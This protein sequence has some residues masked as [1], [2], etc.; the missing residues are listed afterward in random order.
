[1]LWVTLGAA[2]ALGALLLATRQMVTSNA[3]ERVADSQTAAK[4]AFDRLIESRAAAAAVQIRLIAELPV[5]RAHMT[6]A[7]VAGDRATIEALADHYRV[8]LTSDFCLVTDA[9]G[10]WLG[11]SGWPAN[12]QAPPPL[13][14]GIKEARANRSHRAILSIGTQLYLVVFEPA[15]FADEVIG[16]LAAGYRLDDGV[17]RALAEVTHTD[18][19]LLAG[20]FISGSSLAGAELAGLTELVAGDTT[21]LSA[22]GPSPSV[23]RLGAGQY[24]SRKYPLATAA[25]NQMPLWLVLHV[26]WEPTHRFLRKIRIGLIWIGLGT[27]LLALTASVIGSRRVTQPFSEIAEVARSIAAGQWDQRVPVRSGAEAT[28]M[29]TAFN[30]MTASLTHWHSEAITQEAMRKSEERFQIAMRETNVQL[31][32]VNAQLAVAKDKAEDAS[33]AKSEFVANMSHELRTPMNGIVGMT[34]LALQTALS[35]EQREYIE[36][37]KTSADSLMLLINDVLDFAKIEAGRL[38]LDPVEF[39]LRDQVFGALKVVAFHAQQKGLELTCRVPASVP[40]AVVGDPKRLRQVLLNLVGNAVKFTAHGEVAVEVAYT[41]ADEGTLRFS[42]CDTGIGIPADKQHIIFD[43][44]SQAD[45]STTRRFGGTGLGLTISSRLIALMGG[46]IWLESEEGHGSRFQFTIRAPRTGAADPIHIAPL[47]DARVLIVAGNAALGR[48]VSE[49]V[50]GWSMRPTMVDGEGAAER[51]LH[52]AC[53][54]GDPFQI[55]LLDGSMP[56]AIEVA[57]RVRDDSSSGTAVIALLTLDAGNDGVLAY[58]AAGIAA[59]VTKP[60]HPAELLSAINM[61]ARC[62]AV[63][64][65]SE[66]TARPS[67]RAHTRPLRILVAEDNR[68]NQRLA[69]MLLEKQGHHVVVAG[70]G[71]E[72]VATLGR[73]TFDLVLMDLQMPNMNGLEATRAIRARGKDTAHRVPIVGLSAH[74]LAADRDQS[75]EAGMDAYLTKPVDAKELF[76][77]IHAVIGAESA[78]GEA[79]AALPNPRDGRT[80][81]E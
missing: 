14:A 70:D 79:A 28:V 37:V 33:R 43:A 46:R 45:A 66:T 50:A 52:E 16:T 71:L 31:T 78:V 1:M 19:T 60:V 68:L 56:G 55:V 18:V 3:L 48:T 63:S 59:H 5:F 53:T 13:L 27:F 4:A 73:Q 81:P 62:K 22:S 51:A 74:A 40:D 77:T 34:G 17:A 29:A 32:A 11:Q 35:D 76:D 39:N 42:V 61:A 75:L 47:P 57:R 30:E 12:T 41:R 36:M 69:V 49:L 72:A 6:N 80:G 2:C 20:H 54:G 10:G 67:A 44:F 38:D 26:D 24:A 9:T 25:S 58:E 64:P 8:A 21:R 65:A 7:T 23:E 15:A